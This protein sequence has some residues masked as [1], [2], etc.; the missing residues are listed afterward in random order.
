MQQARGT[1]LGCDAIWALWPN[2]VPLHTLSEAHKKHLSIFHTDNRDYI[3]VKYDQGNN[4]NRC[5]Q[6]WATSSSCGKHDAYIEI[7]KEKKGSTNV[8]NK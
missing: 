3:P 5:N 6:H 2:H 8:K 4:Q 1:A 7:D